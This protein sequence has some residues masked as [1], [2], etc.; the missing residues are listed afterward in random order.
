LVEAQTFQLQA[1]M[2][3]RPE[4]LLRPDS[5]RFEPGCRAEF[6][7]IHS[8]PLFSAQAITA[9]AGQVYALR[10]LLFFFEGRINFRKGRSFERA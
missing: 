8:D 3:Q 10:L 7:Y 2:F 9:V 5:T 6:C 4:A 1:E